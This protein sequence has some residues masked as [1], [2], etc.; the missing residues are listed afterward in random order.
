MLLTEVLRKYTGK[1]IYYK[2]NNGNG[3][4][5]LIAAGAF[6]YFRKF[7]I[8]FTIIK[9]QEKIDITDKIIFY[10]GG[11][12]L[13]KEYTNASEFL[14]EN[15]TKA[16]RII[17]MPHTI[18]GHSNLLKSL[19]KNVTIFAREKWSFDY[20]QS[21]NLKC[22]VFLDHDLALTLK[23]V[24]FFEYTS[25]IPL[26]LRRRY[27]LSRL[28]SFQFRFNELNCFRTD[29]EKTGIKIPVDNIDLSNVINYRV[30]MDNVLDVERTVADIFKFINYYDIVNTNRLH[31]AIAAGLLKK[32][33]NLYD[34]SYWK[35]KAVYKFS[36][37]NKIDNINFI[38]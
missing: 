35:N 33:V 21:L 15:H 1:K 16:Q 38:S 13:I 12:N 24:N 14:K 23:P 32:Q 5:A 31:I 4:D 6:N 17:L 20:L 9:D 3:G 22:D 25:F 8:D 7:N 11:G 34:N 29:V 10:P 19:E 27:I 2:P 28:K 26:S 36:L 18:N 37:E 30:Q